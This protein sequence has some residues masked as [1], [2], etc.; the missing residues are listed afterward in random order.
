MKKTI[1]SVTLILLL[2]FCCFGQGS[3]AKEAMPSTKKLPLIDKVE[4]TELKVKGDLWDGS[5]IK[6]KRIV[7]GKEAQGIAALWRTQDYGFDA[8]ACHNPAY[9]IKFYSKGQEIL[10]ATLC[11]QCDNICFIAPKLKRCQGF[12]GK[13]RSGKKLLKVFTDTFPDKM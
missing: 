1:F 6:G 4:L 9:A 7:E 2:S 10:Y 11:W 8:A 5:S 13:S 12:S 3:I